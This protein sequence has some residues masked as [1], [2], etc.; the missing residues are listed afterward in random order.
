MTFPKV[1]PIIF[2]ALFLAWLGFLFYLVLDTQHTVISKPQVRI[3]QAVLIVA[4]R[5]EGGKADPTV[6]VAE[7]LKSDPAHLVLVGQK[8]RLIDLLGCKKEHGYSGAG[9]YVIPLTWRRRWQIAAIPPPGVSST[10]SE[11]RHAG[12]S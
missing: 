9:D 8:L 6:S 2:A 7:V 5:D 1:R 3:A 11:P 12:T 4:V 10:A